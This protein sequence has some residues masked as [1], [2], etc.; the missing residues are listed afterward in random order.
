MAH[1]GCV[2][3][4]SVGKNRQKIQVRHRQVFIPEVCCKWLER[5]RFKHMKTI[6][7][8]LPSSACWA[9]GAVTQSPSGGSPQQAATRKLKCI[10]QVGGNIADSDPP[11]KSGSFRE[12]SSKQ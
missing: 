12:V 4:G 3:V 11:R 10:C 7:T 6:S 1:K 8:K 2:L 9:V 5:R